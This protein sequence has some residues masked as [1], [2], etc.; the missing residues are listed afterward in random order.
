MSAG[1]LFGWGRSCSYLRKTN[2]Q[3]ALRCKIFAFFLFPFVHL[4]LIILFRRNKWHPFFSFQIIFKLNHI[5]IEERWTVKN[6]INKHSKQSNSKSYSQNPSS[7]QIQRLFSL[8][9]L[10]PSLN[11]ARRSYCNIKKRCCI[12]TVKQKGIDLWFVP[13]K[14]LS[15]VCRRDTN[16]E[17]ECKKES[18]RQHCLIFKNCKCIMEQKN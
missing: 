16:C 9:C 8:L 14:K 3:T 18:T 17:A 11:S 10:M 13:L 5:H 15:L 7:K 6:V 4:F 1:V 12:F 2:K